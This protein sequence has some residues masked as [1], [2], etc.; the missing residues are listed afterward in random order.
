MLRL[1]WRNVWRNFRRSLLTTLSMAFGLAAIMFGQS[2]IKSVQRQLIEKATGSITGHIQVQH[3]RSKE[4]KF[5]DK[6]I[7][8]PDS[9]EEILRQEPRIKAFG[10]RITITGLVSSTAASVGVLVCAVEPDKESR[11]TAMAGYV[12]QGRFLGPEEKGVAMGD[13]LAQRLDVRLGEKVVVMAQAED[14]SMGAEAF[15]VTGLYHTGS[16]SFDGQIIYVPLKAAQELLACGGKVNQF[17]GRLADIQE[18]ELVQQDLSSRLSGRQVQVLTWKNVDHEIL[19]IQK[20]QDGILD[21]VLI[22]IFLIVALGILNTLLMSLFERVREFGVLMA[23]GARPSWV[24]RLIF[25]E[26]LILAGLGTLLGLV[27]GSTFIA[28]YNHEG[29]H[30]PIGEAMSYFLPFP[31]VIYL[32]YSW[33]HHLYAAACVLLTSF[34]AAIPP[35]LR[36]A[37]M[38]PAEALRHV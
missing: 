22:I 30:L 2:M 27:V 13:K 15:R 17:V 35:A 28:Y 33:P 31:S 14:G 37:R 26:S 12:T 23:I 20:F 5:P 29:L 10:R 25:A 19:S 21:I 34:L 1:A 7:E 38:K 3:R 36:A 6:Y 18:A 11:I 32:N 16:T 24:M 9:I 4:Y 8:D